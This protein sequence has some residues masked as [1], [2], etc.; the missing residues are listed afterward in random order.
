[1]TVPLAVAQQ[2][3]LVVSADLVAAPCSAQ[4]DFPVAV[5]LPVDIAVA[6]HCA[7]AV[8]LVVAVDHAGGLALLAPV[9]Q[10]GLVVALAVGQN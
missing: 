7:H 3:G 5:A 1:M 9:G 4:A 6:K 2:P 10:A 8:D